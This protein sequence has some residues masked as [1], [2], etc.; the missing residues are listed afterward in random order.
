MGKSTVLCALITGLGSSMATEM[1]G[2]IFAFQMMLLLQRCV[3]NVV[4]S[5]N[6]HCYVGKGSRK[7][8]YMPNMI[9]GASNCIPLHMGHKVTMAGTS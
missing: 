1:L 9:Y 4:L 5:T 7:C 8:K 2:A 6:G 3:R